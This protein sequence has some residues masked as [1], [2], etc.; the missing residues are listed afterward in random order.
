MNPGTV[1]PLYWS[2]RGGRR[3]DSEKFQERLRQTGGAGGSRKHR[4]LVQV[5]IK[6]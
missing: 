4:T 2:V 3:V 6:G 5:G 1:G